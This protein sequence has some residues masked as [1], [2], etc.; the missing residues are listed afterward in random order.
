M[1]NVQKRMREAEDIESDEAS[2]SFSIYMGL[3]KE[4]DDL[5]E[6]LRKE[7]EEKRAL[8][9]AFNKLKEAY[10]ELEEDSNKSSKPIATAIKV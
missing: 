2:L 7:K 10:D 6:M 3:R 5:K 8:Q 4:V 9:V 1:T